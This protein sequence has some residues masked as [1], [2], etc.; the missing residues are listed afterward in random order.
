[1]RGQGKTYRWRV[2]ENKGPRDWLPWSLTPHMPTLNP[3]QPP[4]LTVAQPNTGP[5]PQV[6][7]R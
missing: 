1:M 3:L 6:T 2:A 7:G 5:K 4:R